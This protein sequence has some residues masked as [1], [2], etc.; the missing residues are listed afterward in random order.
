M[1]SLVLEIVMHWAATPKQEEE[2]R[3]LG[4]GEAF[5]SEINALSDD[6]YTWWTLFQVERRMASRSNYEALKRLELA[7]AAARG[8][9]RDRA[10]AV[11]WRQQG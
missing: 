4:T 9:H 8:R 3:H 1:T 10:F 5:W 11:R 6:K 7:N 2:D